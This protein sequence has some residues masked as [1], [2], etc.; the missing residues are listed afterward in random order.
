MKKVSTW[1]FI[2]ICIFWVGF[3]FHNSSL[4]GSESNKESYNVL[5]I[6]K[7][8]VSKIDVIKDYNLKD[9]DLN[10][11]VR[12]NAHFFQYFM[13]S[14]FVTYITFAFKLKGKKGIVYILFIVLLVAV[15]DEFYQSF[16][17][18][19]SS[20]VMDVLIDFSGGCFG[21]ICYYFMYYILL[22][23]RKKVHK[24]KPSA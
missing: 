7:R 21:T 14:L 15:L 3:I 5:N 12:K 22:S 1:I 8:Q 18:N 13:L 16:I 24:R 20:S 11:I 6:I 17:P 10:Y 23:K 9:K 19:R 2:L 4:N